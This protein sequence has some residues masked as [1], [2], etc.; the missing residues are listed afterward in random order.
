[1]STWL[2]NI[3][4]SSTGSAI[5]ALMIVLAAIIALAAIWRIYRGLTSGT[6]VAGGRH[7]KARLAVLDAAAID[8]KRRIVLVRRDDVEHLLLIG[9][10]TDVVVE[11]RI[12]PATGLSEPLPSAAPSLE[13]QEPAFLTPAQ[14]A[15]APAPRVPEAAPT[16]MAARHTSA[17]TPTPGGH[18][19]PGPSPQPMHATTPPARGEPPRPA[20]PAA[21]TSSAAAPQTGRESDDYLDRALQAELRRD[22]HHR[23][24]AEADPSLEE[25][26]EKLLGDLSSETRR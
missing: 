9:G 17:A 11:S 13:P 21:G 25:E 18:A 10:P 23:P 24:T 22:P 20:P 5:W 14:P 19:A 7:R 4:G 1:M 16:V 26:M 6:F 12:G 15:A 8:A 2:D 3:G